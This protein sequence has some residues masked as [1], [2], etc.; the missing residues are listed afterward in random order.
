MPI[1]EP[2]PG[3]GTRKRAYGP[4]KQT[5]G[6]VA[7]Y[8]RERAGQEMHVNDIA[9]ALD[10]N[11]GAV[12][13]ACGRVTQIQPVPDRGR[14]WWRWGAAIVPPKEAADYDQLY[15]FVGL[16]GHGPVV[17]GEQDKKLY[18]LEAL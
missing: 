1:M 18:R 2:E 4:R 5:Q 8:M 11:P 17:V 7:L 13:Q 3:A 14:G 9:A 10:L 16:T 12:S 6:P 15:E